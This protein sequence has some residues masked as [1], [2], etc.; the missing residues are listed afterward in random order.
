MNGSPSQRFAYQVR[1]PR[2]GPLGM[3]PLLPVVLHGSRP[4]TAS[5]LVDSGAALNVLPHSLGR[6][7]GCDWDRALAVPDLGGAY[8]T[9]EVRGIALPVSVGGFPPVRLVFAWTATDDVR[10][11]LGQQNFFVEF[12]VCFFRNRSE[13][14]VRPATKPQ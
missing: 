4:V 7:L 3:A 5:A 1:D 12:E 9:V 6:E 2:F 14:D 8:G 13:F 10:L 11:L